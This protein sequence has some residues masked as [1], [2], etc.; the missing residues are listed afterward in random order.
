LTEL[1]ID[2]ES[3]TKIM[4]DNAR[5]VYQ[6]GDEP[7]HRPPHSSADIAAAA[8]ELAEEE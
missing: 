8:R 2:A 7:V 6:L 1:G 3:V 5:K 4:C